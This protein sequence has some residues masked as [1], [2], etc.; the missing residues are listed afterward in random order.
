MVPQY[1]PPPH[2]SLQHWGWVFPVSI[3]VYLLFWR[4]WFVSPAVLLH[5]EL[6]YK[7]MHSLQDL[8]L[9]SSYIIILG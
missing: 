6:L 8:S 4:N 9:G 3:F 2:C 5:E 7:Q 1:H